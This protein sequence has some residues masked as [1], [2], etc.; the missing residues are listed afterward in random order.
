[1]AL[2][3]WLDTWLAGNPDAQAYV[4]KIYYV[5]PGAVI[6]EDATHAGQM[7]SVDAPGR[8]MLLAVVAT[9]AGEAI[10]DM[11]LAMIATSPV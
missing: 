9:P 5:A 3:T 4:T 7:Q 8:T 2:Q 1:M 11:L 10:F 6:P